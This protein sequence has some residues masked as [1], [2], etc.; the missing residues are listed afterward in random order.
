KPTSSGCAR[1]SN[2]IR[3][4]PRS[5]SPNPAAIGCC[6]EAHDRVTG[7]A[8]LIIT[9]AADSGYFPLLQDAVLSVRALAPNIAIGILDLGLDAAQR[10]WLAERRAQLV[11][12][13]WDVS[14][15]DQDRTPQ[16]L[17]AQVAR[18]FL[19]R[20]FPGYEMYFWLDADAWL[21][22]WRAVEPFC[23]A[24]GRAKLAIAPEFD[25]AYKR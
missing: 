19:P 7:S 5:W 11:S 10:G 21:Q 16:T 17:K 20:H 2:A 8:K 14:F 24:A 18:P 12:P 25:R 22:D 23:A 4:A 1:R 15:P 9:S 6:H 13:G 3:R